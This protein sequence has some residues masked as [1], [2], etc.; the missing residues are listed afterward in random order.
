MKNTYCA[1]LC[2]GTLMLSKINSWSNL[3]TTEGCRLVREILKE[4]T[5]GVGTSVDQRHLAASADFL[6]LKNL[7]VANW[8]ETIDNWEILTGSKEA[9]GEFIFLALEELPT[10]NYIEMLE[11]I[12]NLPSD[13]PIYKSTVPRI[14]APRARMQAFLADNYQHPRVIAL[15]NKL[16]P[17]FP[18]STNIG[19]Y[20]IKL[21]NGQA[22][23]EIDDYRNAHVGL[24]GGSHPVI[25]LPTN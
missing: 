17:Q 1:I 5:D 8:N 14:F 3:N 23:Q 7:V 19:K 20:I 18:A 22:K 25:L 2:L 16:K 6:A 13:S 10:V 4:N 9:G 21:L 12:A 15:L 24:L 11:K